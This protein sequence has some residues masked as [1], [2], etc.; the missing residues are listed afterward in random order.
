MA[1]THTAS[2]LSL[3]GGIFIFLNG[4]AAAAMGAVMIAIV[5]THSSIPISSISEAAALGAFMAAMMPFLAP[6]GFAMAAIGIISGII[7]L[8]GAMLMGQK[9]KE[10]N[11]ATRVLIFSIL[12]LLIGG[13]FVIGFVLCL[14]GSLLVLTSKK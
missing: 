7:V 10:R 3:V 13:G 14:I 11:G 5:L 8:Y 12:S 9:G 6:Q 4:L 1:D 2:I